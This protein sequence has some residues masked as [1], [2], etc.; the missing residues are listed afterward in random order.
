[1]TIGF[2]KFCFITINIAT[3]SF[4]EDMCESFSCVYVKISLG[5]EI[6]G[7][8]PYTFCLYKAMPNCFPWWL[9]Q[10][11]LALMQ[12]LHLIIIFSNAWYYQALQL[13]PFK[14]S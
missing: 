3:V 4:L 5:V 10:L 9:F 1:M 8:G 2:F 14:L 7:Y 11:T 13:F 6:I 12:M